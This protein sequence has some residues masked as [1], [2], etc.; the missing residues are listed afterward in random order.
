VSSTIVFRIILLLK[1]IYDLMYKQKHK[2]FPD[3]YRRKD[4]TDLRKGS[5]YLQEC[6]R[7]C[8]SLYSKQE[9]GHQKSTGM[10]VRLCSLSPLG[11]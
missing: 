8:V 7:K 9:F 1:E 4:V 10:P 6:I 2:T 5:Q 11:F 3:D